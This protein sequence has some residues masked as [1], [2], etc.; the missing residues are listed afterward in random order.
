MNRKR[1][2]RRAGTGT[3]VCGCGFGWVGGWFERKR[4]K[5][6]GG[7]LGTLLHLYYLPIR[8]NGVLEHI[9]LTGS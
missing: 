2:G 4:R 5:K 1:E 3:G 8:T 7:V 9:M 6:G